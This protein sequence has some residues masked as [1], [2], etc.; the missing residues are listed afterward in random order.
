MLRKILLSELSCY[1]VG[2]T[3]SVSLWL[4][5]ADFD[6]SIRLL[7]GIDIICTYFTLVIN[8]KMPSENIFHCMIRTFKNYWKIEILDVFAIRPL[9]LFLFI[10]SL[11]LV[12]GEFVGSIFADVIFW[13]SLYKLETR[14]RGENH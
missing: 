11:G 1:V 14:K 13:T 5:G 12:A 8:L 4:C 3:S 10:S 7:I 6:L 2:T 9:F